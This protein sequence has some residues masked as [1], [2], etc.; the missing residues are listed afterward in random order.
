[1]P[2][3]KS[4]RCSWGDEDWDAGSLGSGGTHGLC[5]FL[6]R[7]ILSDAGAVS[8]PSRQPRC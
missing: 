7:N 8:Q 1:M 5:M 3:S 6:F 2:V 4:G